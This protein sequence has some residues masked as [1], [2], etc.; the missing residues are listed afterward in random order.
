MNH[1]IIFREY[2]VLFYES[3]GRVSMLTLKKL[4][5]KIYIFIYP[6]V[7]KKKRFCVLS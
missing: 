6:A 2:C 3:L 4:F 5:L 7:I 1:T